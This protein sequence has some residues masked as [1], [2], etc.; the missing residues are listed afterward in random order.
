MTAETISSSEVMVSWSE[1]SVIDRNGIITEYQVFLQPSN[2]TMIVNFAQ[3]SAVVS[4]LEGNILYN[5]TVSAFTAVGQGPYSSPP[6]Q[7]VTNIGG[8]ATKIK[9]QQQLFCLL[10]CMFVCF[11]I[12]GILQSYFESVTVIS[13]PGGWEGVVTRLVK[14]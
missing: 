2:V 12:Y 10:V 13:K 8:K 7:V 9:K 6:V 11:P 4:G 14:I 5:V 1:V 3:L